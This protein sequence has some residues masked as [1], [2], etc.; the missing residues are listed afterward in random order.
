MFLRTVVPGCRALGLKCHDGFKCSKS[1]ECPKSRDYFLS[2]FEIVNKLKV[3]LKN[4]NLKKN[5]EK[6]PKE[7]EKT[8]TLF[9][10]VK[11]KFITK[12]AVLVKF[13]AKITK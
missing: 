1:R 10:Y 3:D 2:C 4:L 8:P 13:H 11:P 9:K 5:L 12:T 6:K 7:L